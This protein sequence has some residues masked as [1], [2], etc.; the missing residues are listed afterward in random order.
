M[1]LIIIQEANFVSIPKIRNRQMITNQNVRGETHY[2]RNSPFF[3]R[4]K[5]SVWKIALFLIALA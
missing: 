2:V 4:Y 5:I 1:D 3:Q